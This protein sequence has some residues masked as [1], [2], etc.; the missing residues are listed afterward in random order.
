MKFNT[1]LPAALLWFLWT[2]GITHRASHLHVRAFQPLWPRLSVSARSESHRQTMLYSTLESTDVRQQRQDVTQPE[3][4]TLVPL[5][6][7]PIL[8]MSSL[9]LLTPEECDTLRQHFQQGHSH[10]GE[11]LLQRVQEQIDDLTGCPSHAGEPL[12]PRY[13]SYP[14]QQVSDKLLPDGLHV[15]TNNGKLFRHVTCLL[16]LTTNASGA[17]TFPLAKRSTSVLERAAQDLLDSNIHHTLCDRKQARILEEAAEDL[18]ENDESRCGIRV[19]P[20]A[21]MLCVFCNVLENGR[22]DPLSFH[23]GEAG[24]DKEKVL[25]TFFREISLDT[26]GDQA[27]FGQRVA[28][29]RRFLRA[30][31]YPES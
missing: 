10:A 31:Y 6:D 18:Y 17:T 23:G 11:A 27:E 14:P 1:A 5:S 29:T 24:N 2:V 21:G 25:L 26:F 16:Y 4:I 12:L 15:D 13:I 22:P 20:S 19:L 7:A 28:E 8:L 30:R 9:P 3:E